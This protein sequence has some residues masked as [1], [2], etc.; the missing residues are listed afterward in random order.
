[1]DEQSPHK[2]KFVVKTFERFI[3]LCDR[4]RRR[5]H[6]GPWLHNNHKLQ[7]IPAPGTMF[8]T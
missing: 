8:V 1:M 6:R 5:R 2:L 7:P 3:Y 4:T